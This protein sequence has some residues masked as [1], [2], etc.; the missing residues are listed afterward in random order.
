[1]IQGINNNMGGKKAINFAN[2]LLFKIFD[3]KNSKNLKS[4]GS[5]NDGNGVVLR[6]THFM[7]PVSKL[8]QSHASSNGQ[9]NRQST[10]NYKKSS[11]GSSRKRYST[12]R[13][14]STAAAVPV[15]K[16]ATTQHLDTV[17]VNVSMLELK[18]VLISDS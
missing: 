12:R 2:I 6:N 9:L 1:M 17:K 5:G 18:K 11:S 4:S 7:K 10:G 14:A 15:L 16:V 13:V 3:G 8:K